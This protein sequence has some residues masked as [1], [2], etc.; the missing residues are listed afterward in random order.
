MVDGVEQRGLQR[1]ARLV[2]HG[3]QLQPEG[4]IGRGREEKLAVLDFVARQPDRV[5]CL[6]GGRHGCLQRLLGD[7]IEPQRDRFILVR[8]SQPDVPDRIVPDD[9]GGIATAQQLIRI[10]QCGKRRGQIRGQRDRIQVHRLSLCRRTAEQRQRNAGKSIPVGRLSRPFEVPD[11]IQHRLPAGIGRIVGTGKGTRG[12]T[13]LRSSPQTQGCG[14]A[15]LHAEAQN[16]VLRPAYRRRLQPVRTHILPVVQCQR[17]LGSARGAQGQHRTDLCILRHGGIQ[18]LRSQEQAVVLIVIKGHGRAGGRD[19][20]LH[21]R[22][23]GSLAFRLRTMLRVCRPIGRNDGCRF[24]GTPGVC[25]GSRYVGCSAAGTGRNGRTGHKQC[26]EARGNFPAFH[27]FFPFCKHRVPRIGRRRQPTGSGV[28][29][30]SLP[31]SRICRLSFNHRTANTQRF[32]E[33]KQGGDV[34]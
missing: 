24:R 8:R 19:I 15:V 31:Q 10:S 33:T 14:I 25:P 32:P 23:R 21:G 13:R 11:G 17:M 2:R 16:D 20:L 29:R 28:C 7:V 22:D 12:R 9:T 4:A 26:Q 27:S 34:P 5:P 18:P 3:G 30:H 6:I 1:F